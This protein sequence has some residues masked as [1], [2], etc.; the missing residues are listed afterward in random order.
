MPESEA[1]HVSQ[2]P[3]RSA[4]SLILLIEVIFIVKLSAEGITENI[5]MIVN[6]IGILAF[7]LLTW[8]GIPWSRW[9]LVVFLVWRLANIGVDV[10]A[11]MAPGDDRIVGTLSLVVIYVV[12]GSLIAS[13]LGRSRRRAAI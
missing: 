1:K 2:W 7:C 8:R 9:L 11:H 13:P 3:L 5:L 12:T 10:V 6:S 4:L